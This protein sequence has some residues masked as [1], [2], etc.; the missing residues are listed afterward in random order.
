MNR[1]GRNGYLVDATQT[2]PT[3]PT[4]LF[5]EDLPV[6]GCNKLVCARCGA[7][8]RNATGIAFKTRVEVPSD[9]LAALYATADLSS[10]PLLHATQPGW[11]LYVCKCSRWLE[12]SQHACE[13]PDRDALTDPDMPWACT[14]HPTIALPH[15]ID[16][17]RVASVSELRELAVRGL[18][19]V[20]PPRTRERDKPRAAWLARLHSRLQP[21]HA[22]V[23]VN[24]AVGALRGTSATTRAY[25]LHFLRMVQSPVAE[26]VLIESLRTDRALFAD[27]PDEMT[28]F[29]LDTTLEDT[30]W[31]VLARAVPEGEGAC[32][33]ARE[34]ALAGKG[35][36]ALFDALAQGDSSWFAA[37]AEAIAKVSPRQIDALLGS[38]AQAPDGFPVATLRARIRGGGTP[39][40]APVAAASSALT[41]EQAL[42]YRGRPV[43]A[44]DYGSKGHTT[45]NVYAVG[46]FKADLLASTDVAKDAREDMNASL[47]ERG[48]RIGGTHH[49]K[50]YVWV[51]D[52]EGMSVWS[53]ETLVA[54]EKPTGLIKQVRTFIGTGDAG[55][56]GVACVLAGGKEA[57][58]VEER[59]DSFKQDP[60]YDATDLDDDMEWAFYLGQDLALWLGVPHQEHGGA[61]VNTNALV[62]RTALH[63]LAAQVDKL[64]ARGPF[65]PIERSTPAFDRTGGL[66]LRVSPQLDGD[67]R[68]LE[69]V[70][71]NK[72]KARDGQRI[73]K[74]AGNAEVAAFLRSTRA[75]MD[76]LAHM[77]SIL[78]KL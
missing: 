15:D 45:L 28:P 38:F 75:P 50:K 9:Q 19:G 18:H 71:M 6:V 43:A 69:L 49:D 14:G 36:R 46:S 26:A 39:A 64:P 24:A 2:L 23:L 16:G 54:G 70:A 74:R 61:I 22:A 3:D 77:N 13:E 41:F 53:D 47:R 67:A 52:G 27:V 76:V 35:R 5:V 32:E 68:A 33:L 60:F 62:V 37:N 66:T 57:V 51:M 12:T 72:T 25:A 65:A 73:L 21:T 11:R 4:D 31:R 8:V 20:A 10:S 56:R 7:T 17:V 1:C 63:E 34:D 78:D 59:D 29:D 58:I 44:W 30:L 48:L 42:G 40:A 55:R